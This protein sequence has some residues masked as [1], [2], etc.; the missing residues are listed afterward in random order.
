MSDPIL[1]TA[2][3]RLD[4]AR[5]DVR[6][7]EAFIATYHDLKA[8]AGQSQNVAVGLGVVTATALGSVFVT[9][10]KMSITERVAVEIILENG[11]PVPSPEMMSR[12]LAR[13]VVIGG[14]EPSS[15]LA[16]RLS[17]APS[18]RFERGHG[19]TLKS[20]A[21]QMNEAADPNLNKAESAASENSND[22]VT[23]GEVAHHNMS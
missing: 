5:A 13:G 18:L 23:R 7:L 3:Q 17:R 19:W 2:E 16:A 22:A 21:A 10:G 9:T 8:T 15:T 1:Q 20:D 14:K 11:A 4:A 6:R 12:L